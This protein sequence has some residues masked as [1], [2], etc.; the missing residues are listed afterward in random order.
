MTNPLN[1]VT[2]TL[3]SGVIITIALVAAIRIYYEFIA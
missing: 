3:I 2:G 1:T